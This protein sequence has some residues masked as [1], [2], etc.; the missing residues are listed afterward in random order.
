MVQVAGR[1]RRVG[2][3]DQ[4]RGDGP[5]TGQRGVAAV[6]HRSSTVVRARFGLG[7]DTEL[8][9]DL[10]GLDMLDDDADQRDGAGQQ[11]PTV[12]AIGQRTLTAR[13]A[14]NSR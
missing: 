13:L 6:G 11:D 3:D 8:L 5:Q 12:L 2:R 4:Q 14:V 10:L 1:E 9:F 7:V